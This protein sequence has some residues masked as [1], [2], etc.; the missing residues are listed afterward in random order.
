MI[1]TW[2]LI[3]TVYSGTINKA[4]DHYAIRFHSQKSCQKEA[5]RINRVDEQEYYRLRHQMMQIFEDAHC[6][7]D[8]EVK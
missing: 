3:V 7:E 2:L 1:A 6:A 8:K 4:D 5:D